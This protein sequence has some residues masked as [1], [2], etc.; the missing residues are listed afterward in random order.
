MPRFTV[1]YLEDGPNIASITP[2]QVR[3]KLQA[4]SELLPLSAVL[5]GW[6]LPEALVQACRAETAR[7]NTP[8]YRWQPLLTGDGEFVPRPEWQTIGLQGE[9]V[10]GFQN[11][12]EFTFV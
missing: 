10:P 7:T 3:A 12:P 8:L 5:L 9:P 4:A 2:Q 11:M 1:Q 6:H